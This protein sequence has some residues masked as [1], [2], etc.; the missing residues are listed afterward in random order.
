MT[1][2]YIVHGSRSRTDARCPRTDGQLEAPW[3]YGRMPHATSV[4]TLTRFIVE[5][6][7]KHPAA[8]GALSNLL[9]DVTLASKLISREVT[10][11]GLVDVLGATGK[12]N[13]QGEEVQKLDEFAH[14]VVVTTMEHGGHLCC[15]VSEETKE[16]IPI[17]S[18]YPRGEYVLIFDPLDGSS[19]IDVNVSI[20]TIFSIHRRVSEGHDGGLEDCLQPG[21]NQVAAGYIVYGSSTML[22]YTSGSGV[23]GFTLDPSIGEF[24]LSHRDIRIPTPPAR[25]YSINEAYYPRWSRPQQRLVQYLKGL[26]GDNPH[27]FTLRYIGSLVADAHRTLLKGGIFMYPADGQNPDGKLRLL[28][29]AAPMAFLVEQAGGRASNGTSDIMDQ[30]PESLHQHTPLF[31]GS[32]ELVDLAETYLAEEEEK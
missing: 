5:E 9:Y 23:H 11:A 25:Q 12:K 29:E 26:E 13:V 16:I 3:I 18:Q 21:R 32:D 7:R 4:T 15:M 6:E 8:T 22:V 28:Y 20:G 14:E 1:G 19:N 30:N 24:L 31:I 17:P 10:K 27:G 2:A